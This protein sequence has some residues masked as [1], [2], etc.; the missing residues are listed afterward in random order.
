MAHLR[1]QLVQRLKK[2]GVEDRAWPGR[3]DGFSSLHF[4]DKEF[5]HFHDDN[6]LDIR[7][8]KNIINL[9]GLVH[10]AG[11]RVYPNRSKNSQWIEVRFSKPADLE[12][13]VHLVK[14][15]IEQI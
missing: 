5:A 1:S 4:D 11:S 3:N 13:L 9:E 2:L 12:R 6:E 10:P 14:L 7:L 15:A 8:T